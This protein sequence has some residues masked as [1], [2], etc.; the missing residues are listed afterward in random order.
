VFIGYLGA[1]IAFS[2]D[3]VR[4]SE[5]MRGT[6]LDNIVLGLIE[7]T[8]TG[9]VFHYGLSSAAMAWA[10]RRGDQRS[11]VVEVPASAAA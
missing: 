4:E 1:L 9:T 11:A 10:M 7:L 2:F 3:G 6:P 5:I 8:N